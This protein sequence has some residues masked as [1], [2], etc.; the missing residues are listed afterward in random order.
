M[1]VTKGYL[2]VLFLQWLS[3]TPLFPKPGK[4]DSAGPDILLGGDLF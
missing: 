3:V 4:L 2:Q 1:L